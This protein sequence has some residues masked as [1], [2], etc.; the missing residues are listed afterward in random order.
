MKPALKLLS[1][2]IALT[3]G[4]AHKPTGRESLPAVQYRDDA[5]A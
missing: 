5:D 2:A 4:C 1:L 3:A